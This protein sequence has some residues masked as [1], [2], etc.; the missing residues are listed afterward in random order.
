[1]LAL[2]AQGRQLCDLKHWAAVARA[3]SSM[4]SM[5]PSKLQQSSLHDLNV[6]RKLLRGCGFST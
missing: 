4:C 6:S 1:V 2:A 5:S 3:L